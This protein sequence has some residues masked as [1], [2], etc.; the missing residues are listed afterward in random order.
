MKNC[1]GAALLFG[2]G[3]GADADMAVAVAVAAELER[4]VL[5][6]DPILSRKKTG[7]NRREKKKQR[8]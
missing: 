4:I 3:A 8:Q 6:L 2:A 7:T 1:V 5:G